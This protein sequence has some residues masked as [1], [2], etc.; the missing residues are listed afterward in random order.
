MGYQL[1]D[2][3]EIESVM[4]TGYPSWNQPKEIYCECCD[5]DISDE[6]VFEDGEYEYLCVTCLMKKYK[7]EW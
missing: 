1:P 7:K 2:H 5:N 6:E 3:P 4:R